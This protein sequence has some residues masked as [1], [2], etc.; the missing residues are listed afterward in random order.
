[1]RDF[2]LPLR[3]DSELR[4]SLR[5]DPEEHDY[6]MCTK[7][8]CHSLAFYGPVVNFPTDCKYYLKYTHTTKPQIC[9]SLVP[10][11]MQ[12]PKFLYAL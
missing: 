7:L 10:F 5:N 8:S 12:I 1:M 2:R 3:S 4:N 9:T 11:H 6:T